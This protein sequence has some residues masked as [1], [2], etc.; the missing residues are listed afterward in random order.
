MD[1]RSKIALY[2]IAAVI[3][4]MMITEVTKPKPLNWS[5]SYSAA[6]KI[7]L[8]C[9]VLFNELENYSDDEVLEN[10]ES[11]FLYLNDKNVSE[12]RQSLFLI[13]GY[14]RLT[15]QDTDALLNFVDEGNTVFLSSKGL[16]GKLAD[17]LNLSLQIDYT[18]LYKEPALNTFSS[19]SL[20]KN[21]RLFKDVI[22]NAYITSLDTLNSTILGQ[23]SIEKDR[24]TNTHPNYIKTTFGENN[25]AFYFHSNPYAFTNY[26]LLNG[27]E[28]YTATVLS[29]LPKQQI[30]WDNYNKSG[31][32]VIRSPLRYILTNPPLKWALYVSLFGLILFVIFKGKRTQRIIPVIDKLENSTVEFTQTIGELYYQYGDYSNIISKKIQYFLEFIRTKYFLDTNNLNNT[33]IEKLALKSTNTKEE[34]KA[35]VDYLIYLKSKTYHTEDELIELNKKIETFTKNNF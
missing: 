12:K 27:N 4:I 7:P 25:G 31:R 17:T 22:E 19:Q 16:Y 10:T 23:V 20:D 6:D 9:Y 32:K 26:H 35:M 1:K 34:S 21:K 30:I 15:E 3:L 28:D 29:Y 5:D 13:N 8:G 11:I 2:I 18:G 14:V 24:N 33:F